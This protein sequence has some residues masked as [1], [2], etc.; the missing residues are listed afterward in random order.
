MI[1]VKM[2]STNLNKKCIAIVMFGPA[3]PMSGLRPAEYYQV[4]ID[5]SHVSP[6][7]DYIRFGENRGDEI[8]GWQRV[9]AMTICEILGEWQE[10]SPPE[11]AGNSSALTM[12]IIT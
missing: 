5:P 10:G 6:S 1:E 11:L 7:G 2:E 3:T 12:R 4:T 9:E 8:N